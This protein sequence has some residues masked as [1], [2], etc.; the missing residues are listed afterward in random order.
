MFEVLFFAFFFVKGPEGGGLRFNRWNCC[1]I[2]VCIVHTCTYINVKRVNWVL[3]LLQSVRRTVF[4][5]CTVQY[6][7]TVKN[8]K[9]IFGNLVKGI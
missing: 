6:N 3:V 9:W 5:V 2:Y 8:E 1:L 4:H 7:A